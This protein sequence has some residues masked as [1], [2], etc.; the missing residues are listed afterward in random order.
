[1]LIGSPASEILTVAEM[2]AAELIIMGSHGRR[3]LSRLVLGSV[4]EA[5]ARR[6]KCPVL[7]VKSPRRGSN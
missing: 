7:I 6:A 4:T 5:V 2:E 1:M 3:G